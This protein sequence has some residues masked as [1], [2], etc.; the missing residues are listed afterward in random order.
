[1]WKKWRTWADSSG[2][3]TGV[4]GRR[5][6]RTELQ[7]RGNLEAVVRFELTCADAGGFA[8]RALRPLGY[9]A[10]DHW[11]AREESNFQPSVLETAALPG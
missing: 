5:S 1:M 6:I 4:E 7:A 3:Q 11:L 2:R 10:G 9:T 8:I